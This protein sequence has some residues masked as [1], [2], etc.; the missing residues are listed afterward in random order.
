MIENHA[1]RYNS[2]CICNNEMSSS[3]LNQD[4]ILKN[5]TM[6]RPSLV[7]FKANKTNYPLIILLFGAKVQVKNV[8]K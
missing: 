6:I 8:V 4:T 3:N 1:R 2:N 5:S 7:P